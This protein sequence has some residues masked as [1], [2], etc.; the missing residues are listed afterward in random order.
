LNARRAGFQRAEKT[1]EFRAEPCFREQK[2]IDSFRR[3]DPRV[4]R[5]GM[6]LLPP[7][8]SPAG[9]QQ[10]RAALQICQQLC[11]FSERQL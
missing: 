9:D 1:L 4:W 3:G 8:A 11:I 2:R 5:R 10:L 6:L 7:L